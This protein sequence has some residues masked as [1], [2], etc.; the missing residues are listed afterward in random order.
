MPPTNP[1]L[2]PLTRHACEPCRRKKTKCTAERPVCSYCKRLG[3][4]CHYLPRGRP[5]S[6]GGRPR[7]RAA[8]KPIWS[9]SARAAINS[10]DLISYANHAVDSENQRCAD[11]PSHAI[12]LLSMQQTF[13]IFST[14]RPDPS[15]PVISHFIDVYKK[16]I[17]LQ[18][19]PV[20]VEPDLAAKLNTAPR[21][22]LWSF[23]SLMLNFST[24]NFFNGQ[25]STAAEFYSREAEQTV[26]EESSEGVP[27]IELVQ[28]LCLIALKHLKTQKLNRAWMTTGTASRIEALRL[29]SYE[30]LST[31]RDHAQTRSYWLVH[32]LECLFVPIKTTTSDLQIPDY[33]DL[34][35][36]P[37]LPDSSGTEE[38]AQDTVHVTGSSTTEIDRVGIIAHSLRIIDIWGELASYLHT[39]RQG[40]TE[41][42]WSPDSI[43][44]RINLE[45]IDFEAKSPK[46]LFL[47]NAYLSRRTRDEVSRYPE[48]WNRFMVGQL[49]W[50]ATHAIL[51]HPF[52][53]LSLLASRGSIP[54]SCFFMQQRIDMAIYHSNWTFRLLE[55]FDNLM[56]IVDPMIANAM[57]GTATVSWLFQFSKD[58]EIAQKAQNNL[59]KCEEF[60][61]QVAQTWP[62]I[63]QK[64]DALRKLQALARENYRQCS[65]QGTTISFQS[66]WFWDLLSP[67]PSFGANEAR[68]PDLRGETKSE[69]SLKNHFVLPLHDGLGSEPGNPLV[70]LAVDPF[71]VMPGELELFNIDS[72]S[73]DFFQSG[74]WDPI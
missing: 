58:Q 56:D 30:C 43:H 9:T 64:I 44:M 66:A 12:D 40:K 41:K 32:A 5:G 6:D 71:L 15:L 4:R 73:H 46:K 7:R 17:H 22:L 8:R 68:A 49:M 14:A 1:G 24:H 62:H 65:S 45:L 27:A 25:E 10:N 28:A 29:L 16:K 18:P 48:F 74:L 54:P 51:N 53:H 39:L 20:F 52:I 11:Q 55:M 13:D 35:L 34:T 50:H 59:S 33:P 38:A 23:M 63:S 60:L 31:P 67:R 69:I 19:L 47:C 42:P 37:P 36:I 70:G 21:Y 72:L 2:E 57:A 26:M 61:C 3:D